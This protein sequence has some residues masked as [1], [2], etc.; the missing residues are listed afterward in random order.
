MRSYTL[1]WDGYN[2][3]VWD[4]A[5]SVEIMEVV[6]HCFW[7]APGLH[8]QNRLQSKPTYIS[9]SDVVVVFSLG[10]HF[11]SIEKTPRFFRRICST[12][13]NDLRFSRINGLLYFFSHGHIPH[14]TSPYHLLRSNRSLE[15]PGSPQ[16]HS[17]YLYL[18]WHWNHLMRRVFAT[19]SSLLT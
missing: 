2:T 15:I 13:Y 7:C 12:W 4:V 10:T 5:C 14:P 16:R 11:R 17:Q 3:R 8:L 1:F 18:H 6:F 19:V 9:S